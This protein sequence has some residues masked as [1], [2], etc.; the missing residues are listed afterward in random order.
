MQFT[1][2]YYIAQGLE[3]GALHVKQNVVNSNQK[4]ILFLNYFLPIC[5]KN[6]FCLS[7]NNDAIIKSF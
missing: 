1:K 6:Y 7:K 2:N 4:Q 3:V 5:S